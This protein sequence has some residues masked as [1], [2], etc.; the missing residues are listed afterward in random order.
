MS[1]PRV[2]LITES[3]LLGLRLGFSVRMELI[4]SPESSIFPS[5]ILDASGRASLIWVL[6]DSFGGAVVVVDGSKV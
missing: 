3:D 6:Q 2:S 1:S 4:F 5:C